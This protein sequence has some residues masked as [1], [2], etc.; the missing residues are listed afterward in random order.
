MDDSENP[1][2]APLTSGGTADEP[3][4]RSVRRHPWFSRTLTVLLALNAISFAGSCVIPLLVY[5][6][7]T[8]NQPPIAVTLVFALWSLWVVCAWPVVSLTALIYCA[9]VDRGTPWALP[10]AIIAFLMLAAWLGLLLPIL[11]A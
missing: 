1:Y 2:C 3:R 9:T 6:A 8:G 5:P 10:K 7:G 11:F 4:D